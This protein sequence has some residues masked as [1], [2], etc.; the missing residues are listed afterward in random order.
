MKTTRLLPLSLVLAAAVSG[1]GDVGNVNVKLEF[2]EDAL[3]AA[4]KRLLFVTRE[5][6]ANGMG[7]AAL[8]SDAPSGLA[9]NRATIDFPNKNDVVA[10]PVMLSRYPRL[11]L[12]VYAHASRDT[13]TSAPI[14]GGCA[15]VTVD[16]TATT[17]IL[18]E[19]E[20]PPR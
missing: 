7:C 10:A 4:T 3:E 6:P 18:I 13:S 2:T 12:L 14:A 19:M 8:W 9:E 5:A 15:D 1:C 11:T 20:A 16:P 17:E